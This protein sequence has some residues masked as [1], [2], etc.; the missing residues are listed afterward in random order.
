MNKLVLLFRMQQKVEAKRL[1]EE[2]QR[3]FGHILFS[4]IEFLFS[5][6]ESV[7]GRIVTKHFAVSF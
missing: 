7:F 6:E 1:E 5:F 2:G 3:R 4:A